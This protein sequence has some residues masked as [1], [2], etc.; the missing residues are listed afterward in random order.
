MVLTI[1]LSVVTP[2]LNILV[3]PAAPRV[4]PAVPPVLIIVGL[5]A[6]PMAPIVGLPT[7]PL[8]LALL[9]LP[10]TTATRHREKPCL[11]TN[12][13]VGNLRGSDGQ[14]RNA[15][16]QNGYGPC[17]KSFQAFREPQDS[18]LLGLQKGSRKGPKRV[19]GGTSDPTWLRDPFQDSSGTLL[20]P[21]GPLGSSR[22]P[23]GPI[24]GAILEPVQPLKKNGKQN[25]LANFQQNLLLASCCIAALARWRGLP[26]ACG[27]VSRVYS[28][29]SWPN[30][31]SQ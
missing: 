12:R 4:L 2:V 18:G 20:V 10:A 29:Q 28:A 6:A 19:P 17:P 24:R 16:S 30:M 13:S 25:R 5:P 22:A 23:P 27:Y 8:V 31:A 21:S 9:P 26:K 7:V 14:K 3:L 15:F 1:V 11:P